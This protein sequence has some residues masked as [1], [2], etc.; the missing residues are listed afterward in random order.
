MVVDSETVAV[1]AA[2]ELGNTKKQPI[3]LNLRYLTKGQASIR[4]VS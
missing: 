2:P 1:T 3:Y 4:K